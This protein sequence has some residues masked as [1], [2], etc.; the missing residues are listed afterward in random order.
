MLL[1]DLV[2]DPTTDEAQDPDTLFDVFTSWTVDRGLTLY[3]AQEEALIELVSGSNVILA[4][5]TG[6]GKSMVAVGA[7]FAAMASGIRSF[8]TAP[9]KALVSEKFFALCEIFGAQNVGMMTGD[10]SVNAG[11]PIICATAEIVANLALRQGANSDIGQVIMDEFHYYSE[12]DRGWAWQVPLIELPNA[13]FLLMSATLG[14]VSFFRDDLTRRTGRATTV[15]SGSERPVP[16]MFSYVTT[17]IGETIE[18]LVD[19]HLA[20]VYVVHFTQAAALE[21]AQALTSVNV[22]SKE[23][24]QQIADAI[25]QFRFTTG[26]GKTLSRLVRHG[27]G[28]H[29]AGMLPKYRRLVEKLA[30]DGLLKVICGTD[31]LG[32]GINVPI[33]TVLFTGLTKYDGIRT[34]QL[35]AREFHQIA[36]RAGRAGYDT[37]GTVVVE[38]PEHDIENARLIAKAGDDP[39]KLKRVQRKKAPDGFVSWGEP[40]FDRIVAASPEPLQSRFAVSNSMLLNV[41]ARPG[42]CFDAMRHL[43][44]DNHESRPAQRKHILR[45]ITLYRGLVAAGIVEQLD[46]PDA[47]GR[48]ARL[49]VDLQPDF[50]LN[51]PLSPFALATFEL[52]DAESPTHALDVVSVIEATLDDPRQILMAQQHAARGE[53]V[54][55]MKADG[56]EYDERMEL[57]EE[58]T[59][60]KPLAEL[61]V[62]A[63]EIYRGGHPWVSEFALSPKTVVRD[64]IERTMTFAELISHYGLTRSE[65]LVLRYLADAYRALRQ[66]VPPEART[67]EVQDITEWLGELV[68]QVD[69]SLL[70]EWENLTDPG[71]EP[72][73]KP[74]AYGGDSPRPISANP[75]AF[76]VMVRNAMFKRVELAAAGRW[77]ALDELDDGP[78]WEAELAPFFDEYGELGTGPSARGPALF[79]L[80]VGPNRTTVRQILEDPDGD[81][82]WSLNAVVDVDESNASGEI[83][84]DEVTITAG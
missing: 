24:K 60:P 21:R 12:P 22:A 66:T 62:P 71:E 38:A 14:D 2:P 37:L 29:H 63:F 47:D 56:I 70:D 81:Q 34:R 73:A 42:N 79:D 30:Q 48:H 43:L 44:E 15:V 19:T 72:E 8:Y 76:R 45:A 18:E 65:G 32:V 41:I 80:T 40:T 75:R 51:Q 9:I 50:A 10:A 69:S 20:P 61:L 33:R 27:I 53:A 55:Q 5:P 68:R 13:Q 17:P 11:A 6:S 1:T 46:E 49:T 7:H 36:G 84:F 54:A 16:L 82:G 3:P 64:M 39:K 31:T 35:R 59:W 28:V 67:E 26:F 77:A 83:V 57:L 74:E 4:T 52:L 58:V 23:E 25:G 78:D